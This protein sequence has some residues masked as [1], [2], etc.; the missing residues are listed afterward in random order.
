MFCSAAWCRWARS[1]PDRDVV[2]R[3]APMMS[4]MA[5]SGSVGCAI[6]ALRA[7]V[8]SHRERASFKRFESSA[9]SH[10]IGCARTR[11][12]VIPA[13]LAETEEAA[14]QPETLGLSAEHVGGLLLAIGTRFSRTFRR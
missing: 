5:G 11:L 13:E 8:L 1:L 14:I 3:P 12:N 10:P 6:G 9:K 2:H 7:Q 4:I